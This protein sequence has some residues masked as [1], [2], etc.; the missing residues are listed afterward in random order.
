MT[1]EGAVKKAICQYL[2]LA[3]PDIIFWLNHS[4]GGWGGMGKDG[5]WRGR[6]HNSPYDMKGQPD[7]EGVLPDGRYLGIEVKAPKGYPTKEQKIFHELVKKH[8]GLVGV[9]RSIDD[10]KNLLEY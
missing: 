5:K 7:I 3:H 6:S 9:C 8:N 1:P 2:K 4:Q 10:V